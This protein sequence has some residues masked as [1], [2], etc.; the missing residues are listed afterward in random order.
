M[1]HCRRGT[2]AKPGDLIIEFG[3]NVTLPGSQDSVVPSERIAVFDN[4]GTLWSEQPMVFQMLEWITSGLGARFGL[5]VH[6]T[7][8]EREW[9]YDRQSS[10]DDWIVD[11][12]KQQHVAGQ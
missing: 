4:D 8:A 10:L 3:K 6:H 1:N 7:G 11:L 5:C 12:M 9:A 2:A